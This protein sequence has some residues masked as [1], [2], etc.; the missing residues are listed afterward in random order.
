MP[1]RWPVAGA[2]RRPDAKNA[3]RV[4]LVVAVL[5]RLSLAVVNHEANDDHMQVIRIIR[6]TGQ[7]PLKPDCG[8]CFQP[9]LFHA[10]AAARDR[11]WPARAV[12]WGERS[13]GVR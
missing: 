5:L 7:L 10:T 11:L 13:G 4:V 2:M 3:S 9:K 6:A 8:E 1:G 12:R